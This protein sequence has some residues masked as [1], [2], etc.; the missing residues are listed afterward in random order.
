V[1]ARRSLG[2][3][4]REREKADALASGQLEMGR[5]SYGLP[6]L[7]VYEGDTARVRVGA[8]TSIAEEVEFFPGGN[9]RPGRITTFPRYLV[10][11]TAEY[12][13]PASKGDIEVGNDVWIGRGA[14]VLSGVT[15]GD[16]AVV[17]GRAVVADDVRPYAVVVG[18]PAREVR[19]RFR[20]DQVE[21]LRRIGWWT[22]PDEL[23]RERADLLFSEDVDAFIAAYGST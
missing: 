21:A 8:F 13:V 17:G 23:I 16:G 22:W 10:D 14:M 6:V 1:R 15:I 3:R 19:L 12:E 7:R 2:R 20:E 9:H 11:P 4:L 18:N 5:H